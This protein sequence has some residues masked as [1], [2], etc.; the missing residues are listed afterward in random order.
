MNGLE[1]WSFSRP[2]E[3]RVVAGG[4]SAA[5]RTWMSCLPDKTTSNK[6]INQQSVLSCSLLVLNA[7]R[8]EN[9][10]KQASQSIFAVSLMLVN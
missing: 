2:G 6:A 5:H 4:I 10:L 8:G 3:A 7:T 9:L 1:T